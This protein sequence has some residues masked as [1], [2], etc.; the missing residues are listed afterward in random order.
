MDFARWRVRSLTVIHHQ[1]VSLEGRE[2]LSRSRHSAQSTE[3]SFVGKRM[4]DPS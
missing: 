3:G 1:G 4:A 2:L